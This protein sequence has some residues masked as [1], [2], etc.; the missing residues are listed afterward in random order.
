MK[1]HLFEVSFIDSSGF[2]VVT[3]IKHIDEKSALSHLHSVVEVKG[4]NYIKCKS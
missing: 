2:T 1:K 4:L 3:E